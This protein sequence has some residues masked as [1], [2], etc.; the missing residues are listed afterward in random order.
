M[1]PG[2]RRSTTRSPSTAPSA[3]RPSCS[4]V[5]SLTRAPLLARDPSSRTASRSASLPLGHWQESRSWALA[6]LA[7]TPTRGTAQ[8]GS[9]PRLAACTS[10]I[11]LFT[12][13]ACPFAFSAEPAR[14]R[15]RWHYGDQLR[16]T[17]RMIVLTLEPGEAEKLATGPGSLQRALRHAG[18]SRALLRA[19]RRRSPPAARSSPRGLH[20][21]RAPGDAAAA[22]ARAR[23]GRRPARRSGADR[24]ARRATPASIRRS[25]PSGAR[26]D[27]E[28]ALQADIA[29]ARAPLP[30]ARALDHKLGG[31]RRGAALHRAELRVRPLRHGRG[32]GRAGLQ[33]GRGLRGGDREP[34]ARAR[35]AA[36][37]RLGRRD[38]RLGARAARDRR[39]RR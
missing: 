7:S 3:L 5:T 38:P 10:T 27:V 6:L 39:G 11:T 23:H 28:A 17:T 35:A 25:S 24:R 30:A 15:L 13:P 8:R 34:G 1:S 31:P 14:M 9:Q 29:A 12:D 2:N 19:P 32:G 21:P 22:A 16:W 26:D 20:A 36:E 4:K 33:S 18:G 37:A